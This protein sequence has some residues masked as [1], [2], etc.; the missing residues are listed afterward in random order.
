MIYILFFTILLI[1]LGILEKKRHNKYIENIPLIIYVNGTR[2]KSSTTR[3]IAGALRNTNYRVLTKTTGSAACLI[4]EDG[5]EIEIKRKGKARIKE[6]MKYCKLSY[7]RKVDILVLECMAISPEMQWISDKEMVKS[8]IGVITNVHYDHVDKMGKSL[9]QIAEVLALTIPVKGKLVT[10]DEVFF[11]YFKNKG[12]EFGTEVYLTHDEK[13]NND[14]LHDFSYPIFKENLSCSLKVCELLNINQDIALEGM[15]KTNPDIGALKIIKLSYKETELFLIN[16]FAANDYISTLKAW[17][18]CNNWYKNYN[19]FD[20]PL[21]GVF[22]HRKDRSYRIN[23]LEKILKEINIKN[24]IITGSIS[25]NL[26]KRN[27]SNQD[28]NLEQIKSFSFLFKIDD[29]MNYLNNLGKDKILLFG[30]GNIKG[31]GETILKYFEKNG[32]LL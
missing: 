2:G 4:L 14:L 8:D 11:N 15:K 3:L 22:N 19:I 20:F 17:E 10:G 24:L 5:K 25:K 32:E 21:V 23:D 6:Q 13:I 18:K 9:T 12:R 29:F 16:A 31:E 30:I 1:I 26:I 27:I 7:K 28:S